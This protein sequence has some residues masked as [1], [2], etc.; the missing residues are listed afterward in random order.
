MTA[1]RQTYGERRARA[2]A[3]RAERAEVDDPAVV[4]E[5]AAAFLAVRQRSV[6]ETRRRLR[7]LGYPVEPIEVVLDRLLAFGYLDDEAFARAWV[8]SRDRA[9]PQER[10]RPAP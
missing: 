10:D 4:L 6:D 5:A 1:R 7:H 9:R 2:D 3:R 8:E